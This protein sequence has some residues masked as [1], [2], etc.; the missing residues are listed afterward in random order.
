MHMPLD[1]FANKNFIL[2]IVAIPSHVSQ[3]NIKTTAES[4]KKKKKKKTARP[5]LLERESEL[6]PISIP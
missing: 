2:I 1:P 3:I 6:P 5:T 4:F